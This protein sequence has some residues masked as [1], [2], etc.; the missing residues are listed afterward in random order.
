[1]AKSQRP[2]KPE[3]APDPA[4]VY[5]RAKPE[6]ESTTGQLHSTH[7]PTHQKSDQMHKAVGNR[8]KSRQLN[9]QD[10][11]SE[12]SEPTQEEQ[13]QQDLPPQP[14]HSMKEE[15]PTGWDQ[16]PQDIQNPK[17]KRHPRT[18]GK[19]GLD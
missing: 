8:T 18:E 16:A 7:A 1:M 5:E 12:R 19:G 4:R 14:D 15:E 3:D 10:V 17:M 2:L 13:S 6:A 9:S 11:V